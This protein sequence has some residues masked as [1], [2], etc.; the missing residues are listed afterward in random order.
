M[1]NIKQEDSEENLG[2]DDGKR[3]EAR[4]LAALAQLCRKDT[5]QILDEVEARDERYCERLLKESRVSTT[6]I[7]LAHRGIEKLGSF[8]R[9]KCVEALWLNDNALSRIDGLEHNMQIKALYLHTNR[10]LSLKGALQQLR[11]IRILTLYNNLLQDLIS[12]LP[13]LEHLHHLEELDLR[14]N[15]L[16]NEVNYRLRVIYTFPTLTVLDCHQVTAPEREEAQLLFGVRNVSLIAFQRRKPVWRNPVKQPIASLS[17]LTK[18]MYQAIDKT[19]E[20]KTRTLNA[21]N[22]ALWESQRPKPIGTEV[23]MARAV[24][25]VTANIRTLKDVTLIDDVEELQKEDGM[26]A[27]NRPGK[28]FFAFKRFVT[29]EQLA[30]RQIHLEDSW[31]SQTS[32]SSKPSMN[33]TAMSAMPGR[34]AS[35]VTLA[36]S[37]TL[38][39]DM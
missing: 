29:P 15:P 27:A 35:K 30:Q 31:Y 28:D 22:K 14:G 39:A 16:A 25:D 1:K 9:F 34:T 11:H 33:E 21:T 10:I 3:E 38:D 2:G 6:E 17:S 5:I 13:L 24:L 20:R 23:P 32:G 18:E 12:T 7:L 26:A 8:E 37:I 4:R 19:S 36:S